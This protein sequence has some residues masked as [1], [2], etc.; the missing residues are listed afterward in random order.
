[1][2]SSRVAL[3]SADR[4]GVI[5]PQE[6]LSFFSKSKLPKPVL[7]Q[8]WKK[9]A[10]GGKMDAEQFDLAMEFVHYERRQAKR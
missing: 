3:L 8:I 6:A 2:E 4:D 5:D 10:R 9:T 1:M 7:S